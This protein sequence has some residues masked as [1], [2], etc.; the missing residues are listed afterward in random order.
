MSGN[1]SRRGPGRPPSVNT[2][3]MDG[4]K[5]PDVVMPASGNFGYD[6]MDPIEIVTDVMADKKDWADKMAFMNEMVTI[7]LNETTN[8]NEEPRVPVCNGGRKS[9]PIYGNHLPRGIELQVRRYVLEPL[10]RAKPVGVKT[11]QTRDDN[12]AD[13]ARIV[14]SIGT[15]YPFEMI[16]ATQRD[17]DW[18]RSIRAQT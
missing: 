12:G 15:A 11:V 10:L 8:P 4:P 2:A 14:R 17:H 3:E 5:A 18:M 7:R 16:N 13:T 1:E 9:H 6:D